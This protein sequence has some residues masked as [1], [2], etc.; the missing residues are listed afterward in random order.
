MNTKLLITVFLMSFILQRALPVTACMN[1]YELIDGVSTIGINGDEIRKVE[2]NKIDLKKYISSAM[3]CPWYG[4]VIEKECTDVAVAEIYLGEYENALKHLTTLIKHHPKEYNVVITYAVTLEL[5]GKHKE[6]LNFLNKAIEIDPKSHF[7][8]EWIHVKILEYVVKNGTD[9]APTTSIL[10]ID[11]GND[12]IPVAPKGIDVEKLKVELQYQL[13]DRLYFVDGK[14]DAIYGSLLFDY[15][16]SLVLIDHLSASVDYFQ[17]A[18]DFG[19]ESQVLEKRL[20]RYGDWKKKKEEK[21]GES[22]VIEYDNKKKTTK[23]EK[24][25]NMT[26]V[27]ISLSAIAFVLFIFLFIRSQKNK[28][29]KIKSDL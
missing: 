8:S 3:N 24:F 1:E 29:K 6:A 14:K 11:L 25:N 28:K 13:Q 23:P 10:G 26:V 12:S 22:E 17:M 15:A 2:V 7:G 4:P 5:N 18:K 9:K 27:L 19:F 16:N 20:K 21:S